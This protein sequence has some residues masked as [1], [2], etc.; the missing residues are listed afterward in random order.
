VY[1]P[2]SAD[3]VNGNVWVASIGVNQV[4]C[5]QDTSST[6]RKR[7]YVILDINATTA[8]LL[9][10]FYHKTELFVQT[11]QNFL[12]VGKLYWYVVAIRLD[13]LQ[14]TIYTMFRKK[15]IHCSSIYFS[16][17]LDKFYETISEYMYI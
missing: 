10:A 12:Q 7:Y 4:T 15:L 6:Y 3:I 5:Y 9:K 8:M 17:F 13:W 14:Y 2:L 1:R 11:A 16:Q